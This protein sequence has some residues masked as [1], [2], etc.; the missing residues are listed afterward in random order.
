MLR[1]LFLLLMLVSSARSLTQVVCLR[2][3]VVTLASDN[4]QLQDHQQQ[5]C[6][7][8]VDSVHQLV[9]AAV[10]GAEGRLQMGQQQRQQL[11]EVPRSLIIR[12]SSPAGTVRTSSDQA[13]ASDA[14]DYAGLS[15][16]RVDLIRKALHYSAAA[17]QVLLHRLLFAL[18]EDMMIPIHEPHGQQQHPQAQQTA[19]EFLQQH[20]RSALPGGPP[21]FEVGM[22][23]LRCQLPRDRGGGG[24]G[25]SREP[26]R[27]SV[28]LGD[29]ETSSSAC[30]EWASTL[31]DHLRTHAMLHR[32]SN[33]RNNSGG[34]GGSGSA[35][36]AAQQRLHT[37]DPMVQVMHQDPDAAA[38][39]AAA[40]ATSAPESGGK[41]LDFMVEVKSGGAGVEVQ[42]TLDGGRQ[43]ARVCCNAQADLCLL[44]FLEEVALLVGRDDL[45]KRSL[46]LLRAWWHY[47]T[48]AYVGE[49]IG[50]YLPDAALCVM[51]CAIFNLHAAAIRTPLQALALFL[52]QYSEY[53]PATQVI[54]LQGLRAFDAV[55]AD[56]ALG[57]DTAQ[58]GQE[59]QMMLLGPDFI[60]KHWLLANPNETP[61][62]ALAPSPKGG[63]AGQD[64]F[65][66]DNDSRCAEASIADQT[67]PDQSLGGDEGG[68]EGLTQASLDTEKVQAAA[69]LKTK[70][71]THFAAAFVN[72]CELSSLDED[73][74]NCAEGSGISKKATASYLHSPGSGVFQRRVF[75]V[76]HP[77]LFVNL[78]PAPPVLSSSRLVRLSKVWRSGNTGLAGKVTNERGWGNGCSGAVW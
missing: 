70:F 52:A 47:E 77:F 55:S 33:R 27:L 58:Q 5:H 46:L 59:G 4:A 43:E 38:R 74:S 31:A 7:N 2:D 23:A 45:F 3:A 9:A 67:G 69:A 48:V 1:L 51:L 39:A 10:K 73:S 54:T 57:L 19:V 30:A 36:K 56:A 22:H 76:L 64:G 15:P 72:S 13:A 12:D 6:S 20:I 32:I 49:S 53:D 78:A 50:H 42:L 68:A 65:A 75:N 37:V 8:Q 40:P 14:A 11:D 44:A 66:F 63:S 25:A 62:P 35:G 34:G 61:V 18:Q 16:V 71:C 26:L 21:S 17:D 41:G 60:L 24:G 28:L 29:A